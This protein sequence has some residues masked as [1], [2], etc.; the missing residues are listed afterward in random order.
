MIMIHW[1]PVVC[2]ADTYR[3]LV[4]AEHLG[5]R[6]GDDRDVDIGTGSEIVKDTGADG[7]GNKSDSLSSLDSQPTVQGLSGKG[8]AHGH[9]LLVARLKDGHGSE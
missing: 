9:V 8:E 3:H 6:F 4:V 2:V 7:S 1:K 5:T